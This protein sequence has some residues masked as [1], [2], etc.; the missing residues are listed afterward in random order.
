MPRLVAADIT[1]AKAE[2]P[3]PEVTSSYD[4]ATQ[5]LTV[6][7]V[8]DM[9]YPDEAIVNRLGKVPKDENGNPTG[10]PRPVTSK[11]YGK[12][13]KIPL[14]FADAENNPVMLKLSIYANTAEAEQDTSDDED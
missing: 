11:T 1:A 6:T 9:N 10:D 3:K 5:K 7:S 14:G 2:L 13:N 4:E 12:G 8:F